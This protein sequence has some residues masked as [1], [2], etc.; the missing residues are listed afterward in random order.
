M[1]KKLVITEKPSVAGDIAAA[2]S[3]KKNTR[4]TL[5]VKIT[6]LHGRLVMLELQDPED[7]D[8]KYKSWLLK[9]LPII[10]QKIQVESS[11]QNQRSVSCH[12]RSVKTE[13]VTSVINAC[14]AMKVNSY[15]RGGRKKKVKK[16]LERL[17]LSSM[18]REAI[19]SGFDNLLPGSQFDGL[20]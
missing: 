9:D 18:T 5:K 10:P 12:P 7:M 15:L 2:L 17:W 6:L 19:R 4:G 20:R 3:I 13:D 11:F 16:P 14:D 8:K 1:S